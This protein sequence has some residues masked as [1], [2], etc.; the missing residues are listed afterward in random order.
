[1][2]QRCEVEAADGVPVLEKGQDRHMSKAAS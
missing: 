2:S 1:M